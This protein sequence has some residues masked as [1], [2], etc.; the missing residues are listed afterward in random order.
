MRPLRLLLIGVLAA[1]VLAP[2]F[3]APKSGEVKVWQ[4]RP[5]LF[6]DGKP[7]LPVFYAL[8]HAYGA[9]WSWEEVPQRNLKNFAE[10]GFRLFQLD[11][12]FEDIWPAHSK[13]LNLDKARRQIRG[14]LEVC[15]DAAIVLRVHVN[16]PFWWNEANRGECTVYA[17]GPVDTR[18][19]GPPFNNEDGD[20]DRPLRA[21]LASRKWQREAGDKLREFC[22]ELSATPE[23]DSLIGMHISCGVYGEWH[24]WGFPDH[25]PD[26]SP[27][28]TNY[29]REWLKTHYSDDAA[30]RKGWNDPTATRASAEVPSLTAREL[31]NDGYFRDPQREQKL[32]DY[33]RAQHECVVENIEFFTRIAKESWPRPLVVGVFYGYLHSTFSRQAAGGHLEIERVMRCPTVDYLS[34]PQSYWG[35]TQKLGGSGNSRGVIESAQRAGK[36]WLDELDN[37]WLQAKPDGD[38]ARAKGRFD[39]LYL[40]VLRRSATYPLMRGAGLWYYDFGP[41]ESL[42][43]WDDPRYLADIKRTKE[44]FEARLGASHAS[45]ADTLFVWDQQV[46]YHVQSRWSPISNELIDDA[47]EDALR[48]GVSADQA[49]LSDLQTLDLS[50]YRAILFMNVFRMTTAQRALIRDRVAREGRTLIWNYLPAYTDGSRNDLA[51][52]A[53][54]TGLSLHA[55][56]LAAKPTLQVGDEAHTYQGPIQPLAC[57]ELSGVEVLGNILENGQPGLVR[58]RMSDH[59]TVYASTPLRGSSLYR[60]IFRDAGCHVTNEANDFTYENAGVVLVH[61]KEGGARTIHLRNGKQVRADLPAASTWIFDA[62]TGE[63]LQ[64]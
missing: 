32:L 6:V 49:Y 43:W 47:F 21:S 52:V 64:H 34:A 17:D 15:P 37:G 10:I 53:E 26:T 42:G 59:T 36:L 25:D 28:M 20:I 51:F 48:A 14:L 46:F 5:T 23:G 56:S 13:V 38:P 19:Y 44:F 55:V 30:L 3:A 60:R 31:T 50:R 41:R 57:A 27:A 7:T 2:L 62:E 22:R 61:T 24:Y 12:Y 18:V 9:R 63:V 4:G 29:F 58:K 35:S 8:T 11:L 40:P 39:P 1:V 45:G 16:A 33:F 54:V